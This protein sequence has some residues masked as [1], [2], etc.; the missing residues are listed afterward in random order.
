MEK[1]IITLAT[2]EEATAQEVFDQV[3]N[4]LLTQYRKSQR[5][6]ADPDYPE[7]EYPICLYRGPDDT[8]CAAGCLISDEEY[9]EDCEKKAF[10][11]AYEI[12]MDRPC[13]CHKG[14]IL[15]LQ[16]C[17]DYSTPFTWKTELHKIAAQHNLNSDVVNNY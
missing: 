17:H 13:K 15:D 4:H 1:K 16:K 10:C 9:R 7:M 14:L 6:Y 3:A 5:M 2:L 8:K 12:L 11:E